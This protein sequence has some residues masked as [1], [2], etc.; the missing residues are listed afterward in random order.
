MTASERGK[1]TIIL[2]KSNDLLEGIRSSV[3]ALLREAQMCLESW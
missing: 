3:T 1:E 2:I